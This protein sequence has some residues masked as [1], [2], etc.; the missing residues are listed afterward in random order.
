MLPPGFYCGGVGT[1][2]SA[3]GSAD[4]DVA[5]LSPMDHTELRQ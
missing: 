1:S 5:I 2:T 4:I 3:V